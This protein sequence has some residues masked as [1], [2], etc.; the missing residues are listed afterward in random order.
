MT[1]CWRSPKARGGMV[2]STTAH[3]DA[4]DHEGHGAQ[5]STGRSA[6]N[7]SGITMRAGAGGRDHAQGV[8]LLD[9]LNEQL[10]FT[11][12]R[13]VGDQF[14]DA[15]YHELVS[16]RVTTRCTYPI[17]SRCRRTPVTVPGHRHRFTVIER[18]STSLAS[19]PHRLRVSGPR[20]QFH[21]PVP[22]PPARWPPPPVR[23]VSVA[24]GPPPPDL[25]ARSSRL[26]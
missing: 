7:I 9:F 21:H 15:G 3:G 10:F 22:P 25:S 1:A 17:R 14:D 13:S 23:A 20:P 26:P 6:P 24:P 5:L 2:A 4:N 8:A 12:R 16:S 11:S 18:W 19:T